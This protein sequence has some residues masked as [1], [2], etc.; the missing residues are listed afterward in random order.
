MMTQ[1]GT[2]YQLLDGDTIPQE[3]EHLG[4]R[5]STLQSD[6]TLYGELCKTAEPIEMPF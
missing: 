6:G 1:V 2:R 5:S 3:K 4:G